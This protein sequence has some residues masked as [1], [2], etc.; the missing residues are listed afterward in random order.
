VSLQN[1]AGSLITNPNL[2]G[3]IVMA[4]VINTNVFSINAQRN[5]MRTQSPLQ[6]AMQ[7]LSSGYRVNS[8]KDDAAGLAIAT[9]MTSQIRALNVGIRNANDGLSMAQT[10]EGALD[11]VINNLQRM[12]ELAS[13]A[14]SGQY[15]TTNLADMDIEY[16][17]LADEITRIA[18]NT[19][20][21]GNILLDGTFNK[22]IILSDT[23]AD[24]INVSIST[25][26][27]SLAALS[28]DITTSTNAGASINDID[29]D[30]SKLT[31]ARS[32]MG[33]AANRFEAAIRNIS[34]IVENTEAARSRIMDA[35][36]AA[37][38][39]NMTRYM[40][41]QQAG[42]SILAQ[43]NTIPQQALALLGR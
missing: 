6:Q 25:D 43:A 14:L 37:E 35:D 23:G 26:V 4:L 28:D 39:A 11:E 31:T 13:Q 3:Y 9:T 2:R 15:S 30:L 41:M 32:N 19:K 1:K 34:N 42:V 18:S 22:N 38:T 8:A 20:F 10:A 12:R 21:S 29:S 7:R 24:K 17:Q 5:L 33:A 36:F 27:S 16:Q 40:I